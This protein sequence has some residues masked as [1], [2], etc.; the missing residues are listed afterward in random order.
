MNGAVVPVLTG[1]T[2]WQPV[3]DEVP[4]PEP[5]MLTAAACGAQLRQAHGGAE[6]AEA[7]LTVA[8]EGATHT[9]PPTIALFFR[10]SRL[11]SSMNRPLFHLCHDSVAA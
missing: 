8:I 10:K 9:A 3:P 7:D 2:H 5:L 6:A 4:I 1:I 11:L